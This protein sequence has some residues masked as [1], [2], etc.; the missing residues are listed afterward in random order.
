M[1][2]RTAAFK[3]FKLLKSVSIQ[4]GTD[5]QRPL[6]VIRAENASGK[7]SLL[8]GLRWGLYGL[9]GLD[10]S[11]V[12]LCPLDWP[13]RKPCEVEVSVEFDHTE[14]VPVGKEIV[15]KPSRYRLVRSV[16]E[17]PSGN[18]VQR[19]AEKVALFE[20]RESG[21]LPSQ[22]PEAVVSRI[23]PEEM[24][25]IFFTD[26]DAA[27]SFISSAATKGVRRAQVRDA[28]KSLLG[29]WLLE[30]AQN[31][32]KTAVSTFRA[33][34]AASA[35][36]NEMSQVE[37]E[38]EV[39]QKKQEDLK[40]RLEAAQGRV[41]NLERQYE[42]ADKGLGRALQE[43]NHEELTKRRDRALARKAETGKLE[44]QLK[45]EHQR[46]FQAESLSWALLR[47]SLSK[48]ENRLS[49]L[50]DRGIIPKTTIPVLKDRLEVGECICGT[51]LLPGT[52][53]REK[54]EALIA[55]QK[56]ADDER[57]RLTRLYYEVR[58]ASTE[59]AASPGAWTA[60]LDAVQANRLNV[61][62]LQRESVDE[63]QHCENQIRTIDHAGIELKRDQ[64][65]SIRSNLAA[66]QRDQTELQIALIQSQ[67]RTAD[68]EKRFSDLAVRSKQDA[69]AK[70]RLEAAT[71]VM[72][73]ITR[74]LHS[75]QGAYVERVSKRMNALFMEMIGA[76]PE[77]G[78]LFREACISSSYDIS[79]VTMDGRTIDPE[80]ELNGAS[81]RALTFSFV[82]ALTEVSG[83]VAPRIIDTPLGMMSGAVKR[84]VL[85]LVSQA[86]AGEV[87]RQVVL[88]LTRAEI[89][90]AETELDGLVGHCVTLTN[91][92]HYPVDVMNAP[93]SREP[94]VL[95]CGCGHRSVCS[96]CQRR[97]DGSYGLVL[98]A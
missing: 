30:N 87:D 37:A 15:P 77:Q 91:T 1:K 75:L 92:I 69:T 20:I 10:R 83:V 18:A 56:A 27:L 58:T 79:V 93:S 76:D 33:R 51:S 43:G 19:S 3:N 82:W 48:A 94:A 57:Q 46:L 95:L 84:R 29:V 40:K 32:V 72:E 97:D 12:R 61:M 55:N 50:H 66:Q 62:R 86:Q 13:D 14:F 28:I 96:V 80:F 52:P 16:I 98:K 4:F 35:G 81:K 89:A 7:T 6:T 63:I 64:R 60:D 73:A 78:G 47:K 85:Q 8:N 67:G 17:T 38:L 41:K 90:G 11:D 22:S 31:H 88:L 24:K 74:A 36:S 44:T 65:E 34:V 54:V 45:K 53:G 71:D 5:P 26:G 49:E 59:A 23:L 25:D 2:L 21:A 68:L 9:S 39:E 70:A 42:E